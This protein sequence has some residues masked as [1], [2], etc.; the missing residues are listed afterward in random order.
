MSEILVRLPAGNH[1]VTVHGVV[2]PM[3]KQMFWL[4]LVALLIVAL[5]PAR[6]FANVTRG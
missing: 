4:S 3:Q 6:A 5:I 1:V 2:P